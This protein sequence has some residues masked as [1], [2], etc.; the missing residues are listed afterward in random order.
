MSKNQENSTLVEIPFNQLHL[1]EELKVRDKYTDVDK[2]AET[3]RAEGGLLQPLLVTNGGSKDKPYSVVDGGRRYMA[4]KAL[5]W[6]D[7]PVPCLVKD[8]ES[9]T[10]RMVSEVVAGVAREDFNPVDLCQRV[11]DLCTGDFPV[12]PGEQAPPTLKDTGDKEGDRGM[13]E[14]EMGAWREKRAISKEELAKQMGCSVGHI[15]NVVRT[16]ER[17][18]NEIRRRLRQSKVENLKVPMRVLFQWTTGEAA[19]L[20]DEK[21]MKLVDAW[22]AEQETKEVEQRTRA[23]RNSKTKNGEPVGWVSGRKA[24][25][26]AL[27][28]K[29]LRE[30][31]KE[32]NKDEAL[33][34]EGRIDVCRF[35]L[36]K[37]QN[38]P[39]VSAG[40]L[41][42]LKDAIKEKAKAE[43]A[44]E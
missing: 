1:L 6:G 36:G 18:S 42:A 41:K 40:E 27:A 35:L 5:R 11:H 21:R 19:K 25:D 33:R 34:I 30:K 16:H 8:Y 7:K 44:E 22:I 37:V 10:A 29:I 4:L 39:G 38:I 28:V 14:K 32:A 20:D 26:V 12:V 31:S 15:L 43:A 24:E 3:I 2:L 13:Y 9:A 23:K 17:I